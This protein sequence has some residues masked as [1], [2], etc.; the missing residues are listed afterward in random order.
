M[1]R[2]AL[3]GGIKQMAN[4]VLPA[5]SAYSNMPVCRNHCFLRIAYD[6]AVG[7]KWDQVVTAPFL[8]NA[9]LEQL[10]AAHGIL[11]TLN[12][13]PQASY[14]FNNFSLRCRSKM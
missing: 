10:S 9:T 12:A 7:Q 6:N 14:K 4:E 5:L 13:N 11:Q 3:I 2:E 1:D 8:K